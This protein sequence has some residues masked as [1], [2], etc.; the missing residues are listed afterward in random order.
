MNNG[1]KISGITSVESPH[2]AVNKEY[3]DAHSGGGV[4][5]TD[6]YEKVIGGTTVQAS[7]GVDH[8]GYIELDIISEK[9]P[10]FDGPGEL[11]I[12]VNGDADET[13]WGFNV[14][15]DFNGYVSLSSG[16]AFEG[17]CTAYDSSTQRSGYM[18]LNVQ[19]GSSYVRLYVPKFV[20]VDSE[21]ETKFVPF[22][23]KR[24]YGTIRKIITPV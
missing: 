4:K 5:A 24:A 10:E 12:N 1:A 22:T 21:S 23:L 3:V 19:S 9:I 14:K 7:S 16:F 20:R 11:Q 13:N 2:D 8:G 18:S 15:I 17:N 6:E